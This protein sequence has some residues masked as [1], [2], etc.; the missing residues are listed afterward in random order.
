MSGG[1]GNGAVREFVD[2]FLA[3]ELDEIE[4][5]LEEYGALYNAVGRY[6]GRSGSWQPVDA[7][8][9][10]LVSTTGERVL[11]R[12]EIRADAEDHDVRLLVEW[13]SAGG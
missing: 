12:K 10:A 4:L 1:E 11:Y 5:T 3:G 2:A 7:G 6:P 13:R 8:H 9:F